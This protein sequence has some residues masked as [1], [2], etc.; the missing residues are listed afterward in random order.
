MLSV[1]FFS[2]YDFFGSGAIIYILFHLYSYLTFLL[3]IK[4]SKVQSDPWSAE[5]NLPLVSGLHICSFLIIFLG[6]MEEFLKEAGCF[7]DRCS[8]IQIT[9]FFLVVWSVRLAENHWVLWVNH[10][11]VVWKKFI[12][13]CC[14]QSR[15]S[16]VSGHSSFK[17]HI[18]QL[19]LISQFPSLLASPMILADCSTLHAWFQTSS[20]QT[21]KIFKSKL[22]WL[23]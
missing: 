19:K 11:I 14:S 18:L 8:S 13:V 3:I 4:F 20:F 21:C 15:V 1:S 22:C 6:L 23:C 10:V 7:V 12:L 2:F 9:L 16:Q 17:I 5:R